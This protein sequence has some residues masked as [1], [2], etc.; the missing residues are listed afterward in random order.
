MALVFQ[1]GSNMSS[2]RLNSAVRLNGEAKVIGI[3][4][5][6]SN[7]EFVFDIWS[8]T[9]NCAVANL[10]AGTGRAI[11]GVLYEVPDGLIRRETAG[12]RQ[13]LDAIEGE[14]TNYRRQEVSLRHPDG[15]IVQSPVIT[16]L[17]LYHREGIQTSA[18]Y[19]SHI[20]KGLQDLEVPQDYFE[21]I[22]ACVVK[23]NPVLVEEVSRF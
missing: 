2:Q 15:T 11:W 4:Y 14:G 18:D 17:G 20:L 21:Y 9:N 23:N 5:T 8:R 19:V 16:Y 12:T 7:F 10:L 13:S 22:K 1:Y 3:A 6:E